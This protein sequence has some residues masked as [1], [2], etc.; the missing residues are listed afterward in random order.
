MAML[1]RKENLKD[2]EDLEF[3]LVLHAAGDPRILIRGRRFD[4]RPQIALI[5]WRTREMAKTVAVV[6]IIRP[7]FAFGVL[8]FRADYCNGFSRFG[9]SSQ[10]G[11]GCVH[12]SD[13]PIWLCRVI[14]SLGLDGV[15]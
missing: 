1:K 12:L 7:T 3:L 15:G 14:T 4:L 8:R 5:I 2:G 9:W 10:P 6:S 11:L 13:W